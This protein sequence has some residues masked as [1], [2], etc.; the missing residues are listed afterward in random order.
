MIDAL[1]ILRNSDS[2]GYHSGTT[3]IFETGPKSRSN[4]SKTAK[5]WSFWGDAA[6][7]CGC[8]GFIERDE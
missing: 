6:Q 7:A 4:P 2:S 5:T 8:Y 3:T 1:E